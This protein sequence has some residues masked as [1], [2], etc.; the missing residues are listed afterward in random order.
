MVLLYR[1]SQIREFLISNLFTKILGIDDK[2][3]LIKDPFILFLLNFIPYFLVA[4]IFNYY[5][6]NYLYKKD[7]IIYYSKLEKTRLGPILLGANLNGNN[8]KHILDKYDNNVP[9]HFIFKNE[10]YDIKDSD[11]V[12]IKCMTLGKIK[13]KN[14]NYKLI[15]FN[16]KIQLLFLI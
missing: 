15:K 16:L 8:I 11:D 13:E 6:I 10:E 14:F 5:G 7:D 4:G 2:N 9:I 3:N 1:L 12:N